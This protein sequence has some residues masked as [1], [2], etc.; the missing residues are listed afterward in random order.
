MY[1]LI[2]EGDSPANTGRRA[3]V[4]EPVG[5]GRPRERITPADL[6]QASMD[7][8]PPVVEPDEERAQPIVTRGRGTTPKRSMGDE[9]PGHDDT[10]SRSR[11]PTP[12]LTS[13]RSRMPSSS[14]DVPTPPSE[15]V[16]LPG[17]YSNPKRDDPN[18]ELDLCELAGLLR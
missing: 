8:R 4:A 13:S 2:E 7:D 15:G 10:P 17:G 18:D 12:S 1:D 5:R 3:S 16:S 11:D 6:I 14:E 9:E